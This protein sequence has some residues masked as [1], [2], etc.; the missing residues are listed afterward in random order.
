MIKR[1]IP[2]ATQVMN[3]LLAGIATGDYLH[4]EDQ[5][6]SEG[7]FCKLFKVSR[8]T[9]REALSRLEQQGVIVRKHGIGT[10]LKTEEKVLD[11]GLEHLESINTLASRFGIEI[12][13][14]ELSILEREASKVDSEKLRLPENTKVLE[15][16]RLILTAGKPIAFLVDILPADILNKADLDNGFSGSILDILLR[17]KSTA[18]SHAS[19][20]ITSQKPT[21]SNISK[22]L[23][24]C[25]SDVLLQFESL[26]FSDDG[27]IIDHFF[28]YFVPGYFKFNVVRRITPEMV[29][30]AKDFTHT[31][32]LQATKPVA[33]AYL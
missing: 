23:K 13:M 1:N 27:R 6:L 3:D 7:E 17:N 26:L 14:S 32:K 24:L 29:S 5:L 25:S 33:I 20:D 18:V 8:S 10:F 9:V 30:N 21:D 12:T 16:T 11:T 28:S 22:K 19:T 4:G 15:V 2:L 31:E